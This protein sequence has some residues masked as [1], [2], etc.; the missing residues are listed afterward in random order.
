MVT[1]HGH[2]LWSPFLVTLQGDSMV[3]PH[4]TRPI[5]LLC[6]HDTKMV[7]LLKKK[8]QNDP[9]GVHSGKKNPLQAY[10]LGCPGE[11][12]HSAASRMNHPYKKKKALISSRHCL[13]PPLQHSVLLLP[14]LNLLLPKDT[15]CHPHP[16][17]RNASPSPPDLRTW[18]YRQK[19]KHFYIFNWYS[20]N[21]EPSPRSWGVCLQKAFI[22]IYIYIKEKTYFF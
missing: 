4:T 18:L 16:H 3:T 11:A 12:H 6:A 1:L 8:H 2:P 20:E 9:L 10:I 13:V 7:L 17:P 14:P 19:E 15:T 5:T 22:Y 21:S